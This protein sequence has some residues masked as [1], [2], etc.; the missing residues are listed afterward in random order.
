MLDGEDSWKYTY[1]GAAGHGEEGS[2]IYIL[3]PIMLAVFL[4]LVVAITL[5]AAL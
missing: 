1:S 2:I 5:T 3:A 4:K